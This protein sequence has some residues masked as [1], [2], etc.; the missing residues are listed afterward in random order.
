[1]IS[2]S[3]LTRV[4]QWNT[5]KSPGP[6][7]VT[8]FPT[9]KCN[10]PC[11][12]CWLRWGTY[13]RTY[14]SEMSD[15]RLLELVQ[16]AALLGV[17]DWTIVGGGD[18]MVRGT[19]VMEMCES[20]RA[21]GMDGT[22]HTNGTL[23]KPGHLRRLVDMCWGRL[24]VS[25]DGPTAESNNKIRGAGFEKA[26]AN[27]R[28][29]ENVK[30][31]N[32]ASLPEVS[33]HS[34]ITNLNYDKIED[35]VR[36][37]RDTGCDTVNLTLLLVESDYARPFALSAEQKLE[38]RS[39]VERSIELAQDH[40]IANNFEIFL[41]DEVV[42]DSTN[43]PHGEIVRTESGIAKSMCFEPFTSLTIHPNGLAGPCC[44]FWDEDANSVKD[45]LL[46]DVWYGPYFE[47]LRKDFMENKPKR[48]CA[49]CPSS[50][51]AR[52]ADTRQALCEHAQPASRKAVT[53]LKKTAHSLKSQGLKKTLQKAHSWTKR[54]LLQ[55]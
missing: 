44:V 29:L 54:Q 1:M 20:I 25:L 37:T 10:L 36:L 53:I 35:L 4:L 7:S 5:G 43:M 6:W 24:T 3:R 21:N 40:N 51:Y 34:V 2:D 50:L 27:I 31:T 45:R 8:L 26:I 42:A 19:I 13:D 41:R 14:Q 22:L 17:K 39:H 32:N 11:K 9:N 46:K 55:G 49:L 38:L 28:K 16:E 52:I 12:H 47:Q 33:I 30:A 15:A 18:P 48:Y 23:F